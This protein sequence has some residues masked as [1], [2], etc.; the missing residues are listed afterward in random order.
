MLDKQKKL[1]AIIDQREAVSDIVIDICGQYEK[2]FGNFYL[3]FAEYFKLCLEE[4]I[5]NHSFS[6]KINV[7]KVV[8]NSIHEIVDEIAALSVRTLIFDI[9]ELK[10]TGMLSGDDK[11]A[12]Y[13]FYNELLKDRE[14]IKRLFEKYSVLEN[15]IE[16][17]IKKRI[18][19]IDEC[20]TRF[21]ED[22]DIIVDEFNLAFNILE[23]ILISSGDTHNGGKKVVI[24]EFD[25]QKIVYKPHSLSP[26]KMFN[27]LLDYINKKMQTQVPLKVL[28]CLN[29][30]NYGWQEFVEYK[31]CNIKREIEDYY[32]RIGNYLALFYSLACDDL[33]YENIIASE[34]HPY[35]IDLE[36]LIKN[37][38]VKPAEKV[39]LLELVAKEINTSVLGTM[40]L[41]CK[42]LFS[43]Y[44]C[45]IGGIS[46]SSDEKSQKWKIFKVV[47]QGTDEIQLVQ[48]EDNIAGANNI[49]R[50]EDKAVDTFYY[51]GHIQNGFSEMYE[52]IMRNKGE[53]LDIIEHSDL[54][55]RQVM[56]ATSVYAKFL[57]AST[58]PTYLKNYNEQLKL[59]NKLYKHLDYTKMLE[60]AK[61]D[62]EICAL[63]S[64]D[65]PYFTQRIHEKDLICNDALIISDYYPKALV[66]QMNERLNSMCK[67]D[68]N[69]QLSIIRLSISTLKLDKNKIRF[70]QNKYK[71]KYFIDK[72]NSMECIYE[73]GN[74]FKDHAIFSEDNLSCTWL[75]TTQLENDYNITCVN[76]KLY[77]GGGMLLFIAF[78]AHMENN[79]EY[80]L[81]AQ[82]G[83]TGYEELGY[84]KKV[85]NLSLFTGIGSLIYLYYTYYVLFEQEIYKEK[86]IKQVTRIKENLIKTDMEL[87]IISGISG[88]IIVLLNIYKK[89]HE[90]V[91][92]E[93]AILLGDY[94]YE[95]LSGAGDSY[96]T[97]LSH[98]YSGFAWA[99]IKLGSIVEDGKH[100]S[101]GKKL[102]KIENS[103]YVS[104]K[105]NWKD[106][107]EEGSFASYWCHGSGGIGLARL[108]IQ[109]IL[110]DRQIYQED[111]NSCIEDLYKNGFQRGS[112][113]NHSLCHGNFG[114]IDILL[115]IAQEYK[116]EN[117]MEFIHRQVEI[118]L[119]DISFNGFIAG[120]ENN[121][122][123]NSFMLGLS[124]VGYTLL[125]VNHPQIPSILSMDVV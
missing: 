55:T 50:Y 17:T 118:E 69:K 117:L 81:L 7:E 43:I 100:I 72:V 3:F 39:T 56:R 47:N 109:K 121:I 91:C 15:L 30:D 21:D 51:L 19:L 13:D 37:N 86:L 102:I 22:L 42:T 123:N 1:N 78:L 32:I 113:H 58:F 114:N 111:I 77:E 120:V 99:L 46:G 85:D 54:E 125:R 57:E 107:R 73:L 103:L 12:R 66:S 70:N 4:N 112:S 115:E 23:K 88:T 5:L 9:Y 6:L 79:E 65:I 119:K 20:L 60:K 104:S 36:T 90:P 53:I 29:Y 2:I 26:E 28:K 41:P 105:K 71:V 27:H 80:A 52:F 68:L 63:M 8:I 84:L 61:I 106:K 108:K 14:Y 38:C 83:L 82:K 49:L 110:N 94:L 96:L 31:P 62:A 76:D 59:F 64:R 92:L 44:D 98:G 45:D 97:G 93:N 74:Q 34:S 101:L 116:D 11:F 16:E 40:L 122:D 75:T 10:E 33:H 48:V 67:E 95:K 18:K 35:F 89:L 87:D 124:G 24:L 25:K